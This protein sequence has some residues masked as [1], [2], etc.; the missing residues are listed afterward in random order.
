MKKIITL[1]VFVAVIFLGVGCV[2]NNSS[3]SSNLTSIQTNPVI[4]DVETTVESHP[5][6]GVANYNKLF[7]IFRWGD[8]DFADY[9]FSSVIANNVVVP[10]GTIEQ[11]LVSILDPVAGM[12]V[13]KNVHEDMK[14]AATYDACKAAGAY[15]LIGAR[16]DLTTSD[17]LIFKRVKC[18]VTGYP[19]KITGFKRAENKVRKLEVKVE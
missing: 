15:S 10:Q 5:V 18:V 2:N 14:K 8:K 16:Y 7:G 9:A 19:V 17:Y 13:D 12:L 3:D 6:R 4:Y 11:F 1:F